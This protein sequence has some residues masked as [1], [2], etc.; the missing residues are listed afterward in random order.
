[1]DE[2]LRRP[3]D[4][5]KK[6]YE[7]LIF[8]AKDLLAAKDPSADELA[9]ICN[10]FASAGLS[11]DLIL[12]EVGGDEAKAQDVLAQI[13]QL[14]PAMNELRDFR[15]GRLVES[16]KIQLASIAEGKSVSAELLQILKGRLLA[17]QSGRPGNFFGQLLSELERAIPAA[18]TH[19]AIK[20]TVA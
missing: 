16:V 1:M 4:I 7:G 13:L 3:D 18:E 11:K 2:S 10:V 9:F 19:Q 15:Q 14:R 5:S 20:N 12:K 6:T 8:A 17:E